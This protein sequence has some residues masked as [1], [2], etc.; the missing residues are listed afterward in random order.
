MITLVTIDVGLHICGVAG[1]RLRDLV[2]VDEVHGSE[3]D[4]PEAIARW[5]QL[6][7]ASLATDRRISRDTHAVF[8][9]PQTYDAFGRRDATLERMRHLITAARRRFARSS[10]ITPAQWK[11]QVPKAIS[12]GRISAALT[13]VER[14]LVGRLNRTY[15]AMDAVGIGLHHLGRTSRGRSR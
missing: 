5:A 7:G 12:H 2:A 9:T 8:E 13:P 4:L 6:N 1:W 11:G 15:D 10:V 3:N 14:Q